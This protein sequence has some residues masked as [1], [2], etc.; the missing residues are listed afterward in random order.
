M[1]K[2]LILFIIFFNLENSYADNK[3]AY[4]D[5]DYILNNSIVGKS[6]TEH[7]QKIKDKNDNELLSI[8]K[9]LSDKENGIIKQKNIIEK[10]EFEK[11]IENLKI[12]ISEYR[13]KKLLA[14]K[15]INNKKLDYTKK[16]LTVLDPIISQYVEDNSINIVFPKKNIIIAKKNLD[17]TNSIMNLLNQRLVKIDF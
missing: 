10:V 11:K 14:N 3:I 8:E 7:I 4:I 2:I 15:Q 6:I 5:I 17:I 16:V 1:K 9:H 12:E 13:K